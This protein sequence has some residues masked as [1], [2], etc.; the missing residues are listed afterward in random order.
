MGQTQHTMQ[1]RTVLVPLESHI[2]V[3]EGRHNSIQLFVDAVHCQRQRL[4]VVL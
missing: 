4:D 2:L 1:T 3:R